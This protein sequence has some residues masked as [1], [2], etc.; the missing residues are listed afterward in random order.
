MK[1]G[2]RLF[3]LVASVSASHCIAELGREPAA[4]RGDVATLFDWEDGS[5]PEDLAASFGGSV[6]DLL[7]HLDALL[8][9]RIL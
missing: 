3:P 8:P 9:R 4:Q 6:Y 7:M 1:I 2:G 5:R